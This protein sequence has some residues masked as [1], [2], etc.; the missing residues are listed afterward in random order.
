MLFILDMHPECRFVL[1]QVN[2]S[3]GPYYIPSY[4]CTEMIESKQN[5]H[6]IQL[7]FFS[8]RK[9]IIALRNQILVTFVLLYH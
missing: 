9:E 8:L 6:F 2:K 4:T 7:L 5:V 1:L 3:G